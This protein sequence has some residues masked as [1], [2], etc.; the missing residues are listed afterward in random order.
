MSQQITTHDFLDEVCHR[1]NTIDALLTCGRR[2]PGRGLNY[3]KLM[4]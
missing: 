3:I 2:C 4:I 1:H